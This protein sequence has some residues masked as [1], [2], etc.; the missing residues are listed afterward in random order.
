M[1]LANRKAYF[2]ESED[3]FNNFDE[4][5]KSKIHREMLI[6]SNGEVKKQVLKRNF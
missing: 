3:F 6:Y 5:G 1:I 4:K 2:L